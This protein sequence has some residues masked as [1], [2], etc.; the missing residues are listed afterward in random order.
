MATGTFVQCA[1]IVWAKGLNTKD[2]NK[3]IFP[4]Y[5]EKCLS[6]KAI[7][8]WINK[9]SHGCA[10]VADDAQPGRLAEIVTEAT[11]QWVEKLI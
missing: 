3:E 11:A 2:I 5:S 7:H 4:V 10:K 8:S 1:H 6:C 9:F